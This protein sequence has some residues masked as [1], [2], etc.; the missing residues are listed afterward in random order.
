[1][2]KIAQSLIRIL[3]IAR[4]AEGE[5]VAPIPVRN[6]T[7]KTRVQ[8]IHCWIAFSSIKA[9]ESHVEENSG[10][11]RY[12]RLNA[13]ISQARV[14]ARCNVFEGSNILLC[15][16]LPGAFPEEGMKRRWLMNC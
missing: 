3:F 14:A 15:L 13:N 5:S 10:Q 12:I 9:T 16:G 11:R 7:D 2:P 4:N 6:R 8:T 1:M